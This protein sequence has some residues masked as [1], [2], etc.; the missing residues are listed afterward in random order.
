MKIVI[1]IYD[2]DTPTKYTI[3]LGKQGRLEIRFSLLDQI[4]L[5]LNEFRNGDKFSVGVVSENLDKYLDGNN[6][7]SHMIEFK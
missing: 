7:I 5:K 2:Y 3:M 4:F 6:L 1:D